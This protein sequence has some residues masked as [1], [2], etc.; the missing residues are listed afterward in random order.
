MAQYWKAIKRPIRFIDVVPPKNFK[1]RGQVLEME[2][3][4]PD[5]AVYKTLDFFENKDR[6]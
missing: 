3:I 6:A 4:N 2:L 1:K 5:D